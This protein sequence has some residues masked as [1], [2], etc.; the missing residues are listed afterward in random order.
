MASQ[1]DVAMTT[2]LGPKPATNTTTTTKSTQQQQRLTSRNP[3][4]TYF[5][6]QLYLPTLNPQII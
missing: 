1:E 6:L 2:E 5:K 3:Q 4:W